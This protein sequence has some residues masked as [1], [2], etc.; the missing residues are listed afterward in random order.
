[1]YDPQDSPRSA[2]CVHRIA[3]L[4]NGSLLAPGPPDEVLT[5]ERLPQAYG[6]ALTV[7]QHPLYGTPMVTSLLAR[8][9]TNRL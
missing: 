1:M 9:E 4:A 2:L 5:S 3:L 6:V 8:P 7:T